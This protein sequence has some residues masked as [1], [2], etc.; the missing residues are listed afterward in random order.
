MITGDYSV[1]LES[2]SEFGVECFGLM[3]MQCYRPKAVV[4]Y[5]RKVFVA[6]EN[7][8]RVTFDYNLKGSESDFDI[9]SGRLVENTIF[10]P[11]LVVL[12]VKFNGFLLSYIKDVISEINASELA[13]GKYCLGRATGKEYAYI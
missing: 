9:F 4:S 12:E 8:I 10:D 13:V 7:N 5:T 11:F 2:N 1:L 3:H 6:N